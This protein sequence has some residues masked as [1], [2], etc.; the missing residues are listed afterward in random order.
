MD[1]SAVDEDVTDQYW[2]A[3]QAS[4]LD[5]GL[6]DLNIFSK[7]PKVQLTVK[8]DEVLILE[9]LYLHLS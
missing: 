4:R 3:K 6:V 8:I 5:P 2:S 1:V 9:T 7:D